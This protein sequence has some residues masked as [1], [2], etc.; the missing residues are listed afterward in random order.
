MKVLTMQFLC[1]YCYLSLHLCQ[2]QRY[3]VRIMFSA[4]LHIM[5]WEEPCCVLTNMMNIHYWYIVQGTEGEKDYTTSFQS[6]DEGW[7]N[8][9][10]VQVGDFR[11]FCNIHLNH[12]N[13]LKNNF[14][15]N[16]SKKQ[17]LWKWMIWI[18]LQVLSVSLVSLQLIKSCQPGGSENYYICT[19][20]LF[21]NCHYRHYRDRQW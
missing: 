1:R 7:S 15:C 14:C 12:E 8:S 10:K 13:S 9:S 19:V 17:S 16:N 18:Q 6:E 4:N 20:T 3:Y 2:Y 11:L 5:A 21:K